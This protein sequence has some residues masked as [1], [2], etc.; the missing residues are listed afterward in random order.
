M[1][2]QTFEI[3][4]SKPEPLVIVRKKTKS[5]HDY[6]AIMPY[7]LTDHW[8]KFLLELVNKESYINN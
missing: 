4:N 5:C 7:D 1:D 2:T 8:N 3:D 6:K